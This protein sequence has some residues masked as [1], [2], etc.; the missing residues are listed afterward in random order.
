VI[1]NEFTESVEPF[2]LEALFVVSMWLLIIT[3]LVNVAGRAVV[4]RAARNVR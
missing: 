4:A 1:A 2:H 3:F